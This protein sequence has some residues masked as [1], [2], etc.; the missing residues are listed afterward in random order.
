MAAG[1]AVEQVA[2]V[3]VVSERMRPGS[4]ERHITQQYVHEL[5]Q[6]IEASPSEELAH[7]RHARIIL[8]R[9]V[10]AISVLDHCHGAKFVDV[11]NTVVKAVTVLAEK[12]GPGAVEFYGDRYTEHDGREEKETGG[13]DDIIEQRL[14]DITPI[15]DGLGLYLEE[16]QRSQPRAGEYWRL[17]FH[18]A[19]PNIQRQNTEFL[20][21]VNGMLMG[22]TRYRHYHFVDLAA[23]THSDE[24]VD[25]V[26]VSWLGV[27]PPVDKYAGYPDAR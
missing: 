9:L 19:Q 25:G 2:V 6:L 21:E 8:A 4:H 3:L 23:L 12:N 1:I 13:S 26:S 17:Q 20:D 16:V 5:R 10:N 15:A 27:F 7:A 18:R 22:S 14:D 11:D 24:I